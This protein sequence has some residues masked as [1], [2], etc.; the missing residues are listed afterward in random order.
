MDTLGGW[1]AIQYGSCDRCLPLPHPH[2]KRAWY[3]KAFT[4]GSYL[5]LSFQN[6]SLNFKAVKR[7]NFLVSVNLCPGRGDYR[8]TQDRFR[9]RPLG[10]GRWTNLEAGAGK[11]ISFPTQPGWACASCW[12]VNWHSHY[13][14]WVSDL[15]SWSGDA[16]GSLSPGAGTVLSRKGEF[17][18]LN[19]SESSWWGD[20]TQNGRGE[21]SS[22]R[23]SEWESLGEKLWLPQILSLGMGR[24]KTLVSNSNPQIQEKTCLVEE[25]LECFPNLEIVKY[26]ASSGTA[27]K[28]LLHKQK[29]SGKKMK[30]RENSSWEIKREFSLNQEAGLVTDA[31]KPSQGTGNKMNGVHFE[32]LIL[33][34]TYQTFV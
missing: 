23:S 29:R 10:W 34:H 12:G 13:A 21:W 3:L 28:N 20:Q 25:D 18:P 17:R 7:D 22:W 15:Q 11:F 31:K 26:Y 6:F 30:A 5:W 2:L 16:C 19:S 8:E 33:Y 14:F 24:V 9:W 1:V 27:K 4:G 32:L